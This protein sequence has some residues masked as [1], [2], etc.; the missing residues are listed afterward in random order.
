MYRY[1]ATVEIFVHLRDAQVSTVY[2][3]EMRRREALPLTTTHQSLAPYERSDGLYPL[4]RMDLLDHHT[5]V[6]GRFVPLRDQ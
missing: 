1:V 2:T 5:L 4:Y 6:K 3:V